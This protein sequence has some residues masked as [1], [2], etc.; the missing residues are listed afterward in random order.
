MVYKKLTNA[1]YLEKSAKELG[2]KQTYRDG[3]FQ[4][5][6][7]NGVEHKFLSSSSDGNDSVA[8]RVCKN[9]IRA[10]NLLEHWGYPVMPSILYTTDEEA[11]EFLTKHGKIVVKP[12]DSSFGKGVT[13]NIL[14]ADDMFEAIS[15]AVDK[16][17]SSIVMLQKQTTGTDHRILVIGQKEVFVMK[18]NTPI[19]LGDGVS[20]I[21]E[22]VDGENSKRLRSF[23]VHKP[24]E[25][26]DRVNTL[27]QKLNLSEDTVLSSGEKM[28]WDMAVGVEQYRI[29][30]EVADDT[31]D[32][33]KQVSV[34]ISSKLGMD[35]IGLDIMTDDISDINCPYTIVEI[36]S[37]PGLSWHMKP[38][39]GKSYNVAEALLKHTFGIE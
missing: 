22:L 35:L 3:A 6:E 19:L 14:D 30:E 28:E 7:H 10:N 4:I 26:T 38:A 12:L 8:D 2:V 15:F 37:N 36:N 17:Q 39:V 27:L 29:M 18:K 9:K 20:T 1:E 13:I 32:I 31:I 16:S 5:F 21:R 11:L 25:I 23:E 24:L 34:E 33:I